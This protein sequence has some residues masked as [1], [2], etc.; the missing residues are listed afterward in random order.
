MPAHGC[1]TVY[2]YVPPTPGLRVATVKEDGGMV[3]ACKV[4]YLLAEETRAPFRR[5]K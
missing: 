2:L 5:G 4:L 1:D 3:W